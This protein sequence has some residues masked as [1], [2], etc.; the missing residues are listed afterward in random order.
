M[1]INLRGFRQGI[2]ED[3]EENDTCTDLEEED[4][5]RKKGQAVAAVFQRISPIDLISVE[6]WIEIQS[7]ELLECITKLQRENN[8]FQQQVEELQKKS[9]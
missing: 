5:Q 3:E 6:S 1:D 8:Y 4:L 9:K 7:L 2:I